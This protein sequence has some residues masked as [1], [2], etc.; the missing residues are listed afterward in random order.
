MVALVIR[1]Q[2]NS[3]LRFC[4]LGVIIQLNNSGR[5]SLNTHIT[6]LYLQHEQSP[7]GKLKK[8]TGAFIS[9]YWATRLN[10]ITEQ[11]F[12][13]ERSSNTT[14]KQLVIVCVKKASMLYG[15]E[16]DFLMETMFFLPSRSLVSVS[17]LGLRSRDAN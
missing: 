3:V 17:C 8:H 16:F 1:W 15:F 2:I 10:L 13:Q 14:I 12:D 9:S 11:M 5:K 6:V 7:R 4:L